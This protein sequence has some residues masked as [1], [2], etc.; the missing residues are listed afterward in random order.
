MV[1]ETQI[2]DINNKIKKKAKEMKKATILGKKIEGKAQQI[3]GE[4]Q[5]AVGDRV[6]GTMN[7]TA[8]KTKVAIANLENKLVKNA[9]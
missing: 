4:I 1:L 8:G 9:K 2:L 5:Y 6:K 7:K 3:K